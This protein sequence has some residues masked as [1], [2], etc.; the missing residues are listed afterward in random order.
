M[1]NLNAIELWL[2]LDLG[3]ITA[4]LPRVILQRR[5]SAATLAWVVII[6]LL[7]FLGLI[8]YWILGET[9]LKIRRHRRKKI[10][11]QL[12]HSLQRFICP[13]SDREINH[14][15]LPPSLLDL[16]RTLDDRGPIP[17]NQITL[18]RDGPQA[19]DALEQAI[20]DARHHVH[21][22]FYIFK[23][24]PTGRRI[25]DALTRACRRGVHVRVLV[26]DVGSRRARL[27]FFQPLIDA[28][29]QVAR[30]LPVNPLS[31]QWVIN[32][33]NHRKIVV[34]DGATGF[35]GGMNIGDEYAGIGVR[36]WRDLQAGIK[37]P[38]VRELQGVF[39]EDWFHATGEDLVRSDYFP[40][41]QKHGAV[42]AQ[43]LASGPTDGDWQNIYTLLFA[44]INLARKNVWIETPYFVPDQPLLKALSTT[45]LRGVDVRL[46]FPATSD[47]PLVHY[48]GRSFYDELLE[49]GVRIFEYQ[50]TFTHAKT[51]TIDGVF[52]TI[53]SAN[54]DQRSFRLNFEANLFCYSP[55]VAGDLEDNFLSNHEQSVEITLAQRQKV[56][57]AQ[58][59]L[60]GTARLLAP[61]L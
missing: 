10:E 6:V 41:A 15:S 12:A 8:A 61:L 31:R 14:I 22:L 18:Y 59:L 43:L 46:L 58:R 33:R 23:P 60:E 20:D 1:L 40:P 13:C 34:V 27:R 54:M 35:T 9:R 29:G 21:F 38:V 51:V 26:D 4:L 32:F 47:H 39:C 36:G 19:F 11:Q 53:G 24:D 2:V 44:A 37:G 16:S 56:P 45:A 48:A 50:N 7:P 5:D 28:G 30:F 25:R 52:T 49:T 55:E 17:G 57:K 42:P 3:I